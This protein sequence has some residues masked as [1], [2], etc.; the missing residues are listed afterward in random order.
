MTTG[1]LRDHTF[2]GIQEFDHRLPN[3]WLWTFYGAC[4]FSVVYW[5]HYHTLGTGALPGEA[6]LLEQQAAADRM[7]EEMARNPIT[8][9]SLLKAAE[10]PAFVTE[11]EKI[12][13]QFC[14]Q[15]HGPTGNGMLAGG[16]PG[17]GPNLTDG[18][19]IN[20]GTPMEIYHTVMEGGRPGKGMQSW[21]GNGH[22]FVQR[23]VAYVLTIKGRNV[24]GGKDP[25]P[26][27]KEVR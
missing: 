5:I 16:V 15:C 14:A 13:M 25:E 6:Y 21:K 8:T 7:A 26:E 9:E 10:N 18:F 22:L 17:A 1:E 3:W 23:A 20:G 4:I 11:G 27:A 19:W 2:D 12:F 24:P